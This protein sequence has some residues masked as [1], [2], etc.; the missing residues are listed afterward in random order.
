MG[1]VLYKYVQIQQVILAI[2]ILILTVTVWMIVEM[3]TLQAVVDTQGLDSVML[4]VFV[5]LMKEYVT[6]LGHVLI[7]LDQGL[8]QRL[9]PQAHQVEAVP[10]QELVSLQHQIV[11]AMEELQQV[12]PVMGGNFAAVAP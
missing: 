6:S 9:L 8:A 12:E 7:P 2:Q 4:Q 3:Q 10:A 11:E 5:K 1:S